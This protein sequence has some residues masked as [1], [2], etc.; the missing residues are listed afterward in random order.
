MPSRRGYLAGALVLAS[1]A[2]CADLDPSGGG[3]DEPG[4][5]DADATDEPAATGTDEATDTTTETESG[6]DELAQRPDPDLPIRVQ[7]RHDEPRT[8]SLTVARE[9]GDVVYESV[10]E[11]DAGDDYEAYNLQEADPEGV[12]RFDVVAEADDSRREISVRTNECYGDARVG[13]DATGELFAS[14]D[15]C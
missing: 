13:F 3:G 12:E 9:G 4:T 11:L 6:H 5:G 10:L 8:L 2:G 15:I 14:Y 7:N 1:A